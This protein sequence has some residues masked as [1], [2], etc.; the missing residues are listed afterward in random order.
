MSAEGISRS[1][2]ETER[3]GERLASGLLPGAVVYLLGRLGAG[4][5]ALARGLARGLGAA[6]REV[7]SP[8]FAILHEYAGDDGRIRLRHLDLYRLKDDEKELAI[9][10]LPDS[11]SGAPVAVEWP[12]ET[13][14]RLLPPTIEVSIE[15]LPDGARRIAVSSQLS[16]LSQ[17][18]NAESRRAP[19]TDS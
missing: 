8:S 6:P 16:A 17:A 9:L 13:V 18:P 10:G 4:K 11:M 2:E 14:R 12:G 1:E 3:F 5:T 19:G 7:A 15:I